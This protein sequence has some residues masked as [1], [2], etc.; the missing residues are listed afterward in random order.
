MP[1]RAPLERIAEVELAVF[2]EVQQGA[3]IQRIVACEENGIGE[4]KSGLP[5]ARIA[6]LEQALLA[7]DVA[8]PERPPAPPLGQPTL[9][10]RELRGW[11]V[12]WEEVEE[13]RQLGHGAFGVVTLV[14]C[15]GHDMACKKITANTGAEHEQ[16]AKMLLREVKSLSEVHH[17]NVV[18]LMGVCVERHHLCVLLELGGRGS[19][20]Q[21][22]DDHPELPLWRRFQLLHGAALGCAALHAH[23]PRPIVHHDIK[24]VN[25]LVTRDWICKLADF[26]MATGLGTLPT[27]TKAGGGGTLQFTAPEVMNKQPYSLAAETYA[28]GV[29]MYE[30]ATG[31][32]P[33]AGCSM[34]DIYLAVGVHGERPPIPP[35]CHPFLAETIPSCWAQDPAARPSSAALAAAFAGAAAGGDATLLPP[36]LPPP[37]A[38]QPWMAVGQPAGPADG[39]Q[40]RQCDEGCRAAMVPPLHPLY[41]AIS[42]FVINGGGKKGAAARLDIVSIE[43]TWSDDLAQQFDIGVRALERQR[44]QA[45]F[46]ADVE[47]DGEKVALA[48]VADAVCSGR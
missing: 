17:V 3:L 44:Q 40:W 11:A 30:V 47:D 9:L 46:H 15:R 2:G 37:A 21:V 36:D 10:P 41:G 18:R 24:T 29:V 26:G 38:P 48:A 14:K 16:A 27:A 39:L 8:T 1:P 43:L 12:Q 32:A 34:Q 45:F 19:L 42:A 35:G 33:W 4:T 5:L 28:L 6:A 23:T 31:A 22:L 13:V 7:M 20:R 25:L